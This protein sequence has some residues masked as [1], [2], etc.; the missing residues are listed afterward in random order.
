[1]LKYELETLDNTDDAV[2]GLYELVDGGKFRLKVEGIEDT[3][4]LKSALA[5]ERDAAKKAREYQAL[6]LT[7]D[8]IRELK[9]SREAAEDEAARKAGDF[10]KLRDKITAQSQAQIDAIKAEMAAIEASERDARITAGLMSAL[11]EAGATQEGLALLPE[12]MKG[13]A[14]IETVEGQRKIKILDEDGSPMLSNGGKDATFAD[15]VN[16]ASTRFPSLFAAKTK[17][18]S[19][20]PPG[21]NNGA[22]SAQKTV[23][24]TQFDTMSQLERTEFAKSG[25]K[26]VNS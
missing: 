9:A 3:S 4:G 22:G 5:K 25:G 21:G 13:R 18:G 20:T 7:P 15:L 17:T 8:E 23:T 14:K 24:R 12:I 19:G 16:A 10:D 1:M 11:S 2:K 26:V 6:G